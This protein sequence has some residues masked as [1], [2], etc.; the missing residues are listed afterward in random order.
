MMKEEKIALIESRLSDAES[1]NIFKLRLNYSKTGDYSYIHN[2]VRSTVAYQ[3]IRTA[4]GKTEKKVAAYG[5]GFWGQEIIAL[6]QDEIEWAYCIDRE[7]KIP[8]LNGIPVV[9]LENILG[10][11]EQ[12]FFVITVRNGHKEIYQTLVGAGVLEENIID[13]GQI[14]DELYY[15]QYFDLKVLPKEEDEVFVDGGCFD[16]QTAHAFSEWSGN[17]YKRIYCFE[18]DPVNYKNC[19]K[20]VWDDRI[21][22]L[23]AG[24]WNKSCQLSFNSSGDI[25]SKISE[26]G[27]LLVD[28]VALDAR[29]A[30]EKVTFIKMDIEGAELQALEGAQNIICKYKPKLA[31]CVY[32]LKEDIWAIPEY[33][34][35]LNPSYKLYLRHYSLADNDTVL[36]AL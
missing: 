19:C 32:H 25:A 3:K 14:L 12:L 20:R 31:I 16:L 29:L 1:E 33:I 7:P 21:E 8:M 18:P 23:N 9:T 13:I 15:K 10:Q 27:A 11:I 35:K 2:M 34:L 6:L 28:A 24:L 5:V 36:Y 4:L 22:L 30:K 17:K 26:K